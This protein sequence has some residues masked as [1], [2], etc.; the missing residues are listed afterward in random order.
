MTVQAHP[1]PSTHH[2]ELTALRAAVL[3]HDNDTL[4]ALLD[5]EEYE[6]IAQCDEWPA[7]ATCRLIPQ[8]TAARTSARR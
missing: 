8:D 1:C 4:H 3:V 7:Y 2:L 6:L 5:G